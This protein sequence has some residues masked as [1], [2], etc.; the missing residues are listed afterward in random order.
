MSPQI[1]QQHYPAAAR[2]F[3]WLTAV[4]VLF[5]I[6]A[7]IAM[8]RLPDGPLPDLLYELHRSVGALLLVIVLARLVN[9]MTFSAPPLPQDLPWLQ[10]FAA[11][12]VHA[13]LYVLLVVQPLLGW[14]ASSAYRA[15]ITIFW[16]FELP[17][18]W[19][20]DRAFSDRLFVLHA[21]IGWTIGALLCAHIAGALYHLV[22]RRD[23]VFQRMWRGYPA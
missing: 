9:R 5:N 13:A 18:I 17:P 23:G 19:P 11:S 6:A 3:H 22:I 10:R 12:A 2:L 8:N 16:L 1:D 20:E 7:G 14:V 15:P 4:L 21:W